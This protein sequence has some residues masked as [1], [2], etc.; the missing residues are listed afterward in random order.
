[1]KA[2]ALKKIQS[3]FAALSEF[4]PLHP[5]RTEE[6]YDRA[7]EVMDALLDAGAHTQGHPLGDLLATLG[8]FIG[9]YDDKHYPVGEVSGAEMLRFIMEQH[10]LTQRDLP[11]VGS[12][13]LVSDLLRGK[14]EFNMR[15]VKALKS[16]FGVSADAFA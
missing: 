11:E 16:R 9:D 12:Q 1:M 10:G 13:G 3:H 7:V 2:S 4:V 15:H 14:R 6:E 8:E 5:I